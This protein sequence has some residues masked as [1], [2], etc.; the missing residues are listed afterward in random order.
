[1]VRVNIERAYDDLAYDERNVARIM[2]ALRSDG[3]LNNTVV[4]VTSAAGQTI[5]AKAIRY[6]YA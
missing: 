3:V 1:M 6:G 2:D 4:I 5:E